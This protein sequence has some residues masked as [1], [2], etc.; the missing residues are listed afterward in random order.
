MASA[1]GA[2]TSKYELE[3]GLCFAGADAFSAEIVDQ[4]TICR[5]RDWFDGSTESRHAMPIDQIVELHDDIKAGLD[6]ATE[7]RC[8]SCGSLAFR[9]PRVLDD[10]K[11]VLCAGCGAFVSTYG[12][13]RQRFGEQG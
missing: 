1:V 13:L 10:D 6:P 8:P 12:D 3:R 4:G 5:Q 9:Y 7:F 11:P 2:P